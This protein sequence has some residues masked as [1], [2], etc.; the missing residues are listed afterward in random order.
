[1]FGE[2]NNLLQLDSAFKIGYYVGMARVFEAQLQTFIS[3]WSER[4]PFYSSTSTK[5]SIYLHGFNLPLY[6]LLDQVG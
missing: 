4:V 5:Q 6:F 3:S 1:M 2:T